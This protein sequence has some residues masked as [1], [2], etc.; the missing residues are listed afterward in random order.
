MLV[1]RSELPV[2]DDKGSRKVQKD[3]LAEIYH[4]RHVVVVVMHGRRRCHYIPPWTELAWKSWSVV[5]GRDDAM[6]C[7]YSIHLSMHAHGFSLQEK[8]ARL[9]FVRGSREEA[10]G[11]RGG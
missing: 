7:I 11:S 6:G 2:D 4:Q 9:H 10:A 5:T 1:V 8:K 3:M